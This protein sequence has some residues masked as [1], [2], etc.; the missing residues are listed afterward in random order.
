MWNLFVNWK[1]SQ[2]LF[3]NLKSSPATRHLLPVQLRVAPFNSN[4]GGF[5]RSEVPLPSGQRVDSLPRVLYRLAYHIF[6]S[7]ES[8]VLVRDVQR[9]GVGSPIGVRWFE[10]H[11]VGTRYF[12]P[13]KERTLQMMA[14][15]CDTWLFCTTI[16]ANIISRICFYFIHFRCL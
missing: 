12:F 16:A 1:S 15:L 9:A 11:R 13:N 4:V 2:N 14:R 3:V 8:M 6:G 7:Y 5:C 10:I